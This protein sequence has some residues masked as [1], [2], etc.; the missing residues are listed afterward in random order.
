MSKRNTQ[1]N[2]AAARDRLRAEREAQAKK[3]KTRKQVVVA[4]SV[5]AAAVHRIMT[6]LRS[7]GGPAPRD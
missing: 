7:P 5:V 3:D 1:Q 4:V 6:E 2:K